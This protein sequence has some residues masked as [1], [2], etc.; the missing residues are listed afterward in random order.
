MPRRDDDLE[1]RDVRVE[2]PTLPDDLNRAVTDELQ[3]AVGAKRA[4]VPRGTP[5]RERDLRSPGGG[6]SALLGRN[7]LL[8]AITAIAAIVVG[9]IV[10][11]ASAEWWTLFIPVGV[12]A[13]GTLAIGFMVV[14]MTS[15]PEAPD[16]RLTARL[17]DAGVPAPERRFNELVS[18]FA[19]AP[20]ASGATDIVTT[21]DNAR[22]TPADADPGAA[23]AEQRTAMTPTHGAS[24]PA[25]GGSAIMGVEWTAVVGAVVLAIVIAIAGGGAW[26]VLAAVMA[27]CGAAWIGYQRLALRGRDKGARGPRSGRR[28]ALTITIASVL[29]IELL[30]LL[31]VLFGSSGR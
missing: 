13:L 23:Y 30:T 7:R 1:T 16:P 20:D 24:A 6:V 18:E 14:Q 5:H 22:D 15:Q 9:A 31:V 19:G 26:W 4:Q 25:G 2:D 8:I 27:L 10:A 21:D 12:H 17:E 3:K 29:A 11:L 28:R